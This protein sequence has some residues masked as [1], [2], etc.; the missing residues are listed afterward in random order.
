M[1]MHR[2][3]K[4]FTKQKNE[5]TF[6]LYSEIE[7]IHKASFNVFKTTNELLVS[8]G[9]VPVKCIHTFKSTCPNAVLSF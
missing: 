4:R 2:V 3:S 6:F 8:L 5:Y 1:P 7:T 9:Q